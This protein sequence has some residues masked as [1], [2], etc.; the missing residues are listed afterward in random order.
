MPATIHALPLL[1]RRRRLNEYC[2][3]SAVTGDPSWNFAA[4]SSLKTY[5]VPSSETVQDAAR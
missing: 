1:S 2:T 4:G 5:S 3:A